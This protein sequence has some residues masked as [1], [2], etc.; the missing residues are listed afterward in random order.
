M[1]YW[2]ANLIETSQIREKKH[3]NAVPSEGNHSKTSVLDLS[4]LVLL[5]VG[6]VLALLHVSKKGPCF[7]MKLTAERPRGSKEKSPG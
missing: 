4:E 5:E 1:K 2:W 3:A 7:R 6:L